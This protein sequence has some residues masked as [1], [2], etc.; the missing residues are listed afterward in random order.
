VFLDDLAFNEDALFPHDSTT[1]AE[2]LGYYE[3][4]HGL[5]VANEAGEVLTRSAMPAGLILDFR[6]EQPS[7]TV[8]TVPY[9]EGSSRLTLYAE[10]HNRHPD[11]APRL[12]DTPFPPELR[13][14]GKLESELPEPLSTD[15]ATLE[16]ADLVLGWQMR[17]DAP[18][19][20][21]FPF[22][23]ANHREIPE[24]EELAV[25][26]EIYNLQHGVDGFTDFRIDYEVQPVRRMEWL[27]GREQEF[28]LTLDQR[29]T[30]IRFI[31]NLEI[32]TRELPP[33]RYRLKLAATDNLSGQQVERE[34]EFEVVEN[35]ERETVSVN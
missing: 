20:T 16:M 25:H 1:A 13:G 30:Q 3:L 31:E 21:L 28:S 5:T 18:E 14:L 24:N 4:S 12:G 8:F 27:R 34:M 9:T 6:E 11:S 33:G 26:L 2:V 22:V 10:L 17:K 29:T 35:T 15:P 23:V 32:R 7:S 19:G